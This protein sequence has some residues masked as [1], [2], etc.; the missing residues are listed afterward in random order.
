MISPIVLAEKAA[1]Q[2]YVDYLESQ[3]PVYDGAVHWKPNYM[4]DDE[5]RRLFTVW[6]KLRDERD[7]I[8]EP[9][10]FAHRKRVRRFSTRSDR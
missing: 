1:W 5:S 10:H 2:L 6:R 3:M 9:Q 4:G 8:S 7:G